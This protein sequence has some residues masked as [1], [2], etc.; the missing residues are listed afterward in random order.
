MKLRRWAPLW[1]F[2]AGCLS[3]AMLL[4]WHLGH[5]PSLA[6]RESRAPERDVE[7]LRASETKA[8]PTVAYTP[9]VERSEREPAAH[10]AVDENV[11]APSEHGSS[12]ADVLAR[13]EAEYRERSVSKQTTS[14]AVEAKPSVSAA[15]PVEATPAVAASG[16][17]GELPHVD[18]AAKASPEPIRVATVSEPVAAKRTVPDEV[19]PPVVPPPHASTSTPAGAS[20]EVTLV[21]ATAPVTLDEASPSTP[22]GPSVPPLVAPSL[23]QAA[24]PQQIALVQQT[25]LMQQAA[26]AQ[27]VVMLQYLQLVSLGTNARVGAPAVQAGR[28]P[29]G[30]RIVD[31]L[32]STFS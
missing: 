22:T 29:P 2:A 10:L 30:G 27:Q 9:S 24:S 4:G 18:S 13:L 31:T 16:S 1:S 15:D 6:P 20:A 7:P 12:V 28:R 14:S 17:P 23:P 8:A 21:A 11:E 19:P 25:A 32:P 26:L 3:G 5:T